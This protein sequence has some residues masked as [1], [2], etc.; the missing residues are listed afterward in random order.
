MQ[1]I[2]ICIELNEYIFNFEQ[3]CLKVLALLASNA[4]NQDVLHTTFTSS[5]TSFTNIYF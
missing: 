4:L 5:T 2:I 3:I 1:M